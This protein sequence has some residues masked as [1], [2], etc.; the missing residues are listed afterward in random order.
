MTGSVAHRLGRLLSGVVLVT[1][2]TYVFIYLVRWEW[3]RALMAGL[4]FLAAE[5][6]LI[7]DVLLARVRGLEHKIEEERTREQTTA[8]AARLRANR[9]EKPGPFAWLAP[10]H[11]RLNVLLPVLIGAGVVLSGVAYLVE[12]VSR[13]TA[14]P[15]A[16]HELARGLSTMALPIEGLAPLGRPPAARP[17]PVDA[18]PGARLWRWL[19]AGGLVAVLVAGVLAGVQYLMSVP[20]E[21]D[22]GRAL[23]VD[24]VVLNRDLGQPDRD[25]VLALW[26]VCRMRVPDTVELDS[27]EPSGSSQPVRHRLTVSPAPGA[28]DTK[29]LVGCLQDA[30][31]ERARVDVL[32]VEQ[33]SG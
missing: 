16:E 14:V 17:V 6:V 32:A 22:P 11:D 4:F 28:S 30:V 12:Q 18:P 15:V 5:M 24:M 8:L 3:N 9:P 23:T 2:G 29:E 13:V 33:T 10:D 21:P 1:S 25:V 31:I 20:A 27:L 19:T 7:A 26:T